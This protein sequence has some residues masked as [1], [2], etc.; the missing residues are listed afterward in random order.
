MLRF[1]K[2]SKPLLEARGHLLEVDGNRRMVARSARIYECYRQQPR[3]DHCKLCDE[4]LVEPP[5][6]EKFNI[7]YYLCSCGHLSGGFEDTA[8]FNALLYATDGGLAA[9]DYS[10]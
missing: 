9:A 1:G 4:P 8:E 2:S 7:P 5:M 10:D 6:F 3:R